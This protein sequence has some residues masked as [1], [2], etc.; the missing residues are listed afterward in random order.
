[1]WT[2]KPGGEGVSEANG[3]ACALVGYDSGESS[4]KMIVNPMPDMTVT[5]VGSSHYRGDIHKNLASGWVEKV[6]LTETVVSETA[7]PVSAGKLSAVIE[8][9]VKITNLI[10]AEE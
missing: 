6:E 9:R 8:R 10:H 5:T 1:V 2:G 4:F 3:A 7:L